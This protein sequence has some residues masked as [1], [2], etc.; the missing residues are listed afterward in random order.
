[1][2]TLRVA[3]IGAGQI[4]RASHIEN[5]CSFPQV[6][7]V[8]ICDTNLAAA[9]AVAEEYGIPA[10]YGNHL[11]MLEALHPD[12]VSVCVPNAFHCALTC[13]ALEKGCHVY[14]EKPPAL[15]VAE[16]E[17]MC[18]LAEEKGLRLTFGFHFRHGE[19]VSILKQKI[20]AGD[21]GELYGARVQWIRRRG[22]PGW[23]SFTNKA[24]QGGGPLID[25]GSHM[26]DLAFYLMDYPEIDYLCAAA[27]DKIGRKGGVGLFGAWSGERFTVEDSLFG[28]I[29]FRDGASLNLETAFALHT[30]EK[31][32]R[33]VQLFGDKM[34]A[35]LFPLELYT[36]CEG[37]LLNTEYPYLQEQELHK[38]A[39]RNFVEACLK[40][41]ALLVTPE[42]AFY[43]QRVLC[44]F[45]ES[46]ETGRPVFLS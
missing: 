27:H 35:S 14:C 16:V 1:M 25:I 41:E 31:D 42:Q 33:N 34:G 30:K 29:R 17:K 15:T 36:A 26:L 22:I 6:E 11:E 10:Y 12:A 46:A 21:L 28:F 13:D 3:L 2:K 4:V 38:A 39:L 7:L 40:R 8:G 44:A 18:A 5:Y 19:N 32:I 37:Q 45:Y 20:E 23:G 9:K 24:I 43:V